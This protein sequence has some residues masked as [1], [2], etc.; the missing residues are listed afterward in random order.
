[1][2]VS[3]TSLVTP[4]EVRLEEL[5]GKIILIDAMNMLYQF[6]TTIRQYDGTPLKDSKGN[7]TSHLTGLF[8]RCTRLMAKGVKLAFVFDGTMPDLKRAERKRREKLKAEAISALKVAEETNDVEAMKKYAG[9]A[10]KITSEMLEESKALLTVLGIPVIQAPSEGEAQAAYMQQKGD[11]DFVGSQDFDCLLYGAPSMIRN[12]SLSLRRKKINAVTYTTISPEVITLETTLKELELSLTQL[13][14]LGML[15]GTDFSIGGV[16]GLGPKKSLKL[17]Q[18]HGDDLE[19]IFAAAKWDEHQ[20]VSWQ[21]VY[22]LI[23]NMPT[24]DDYSLE[25]S[26]IDTEAV[27]DILVKQHDFNEDRIRNTLKEIEEEKK[28]GRQT[29][30]GQFF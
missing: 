13:R 23:S 10:A 27:V 17:V 18:E 4:K 9:R 15:V 29:G 20:E 11:G 26:E 24:T 14:A 16:K 25:W 19:A 22:E 1:M 28:K 3:L 12:L 7:I 21:E 5:Q 2:G 8:A 30:L 6:V